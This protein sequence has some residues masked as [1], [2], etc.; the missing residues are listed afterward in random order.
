MNIRTSIA[1]LA[2]AFVAASSFAATPTPTDAV[3]FQKVAATA[4]APGALAKAK[5]M[6]CPKA[7]HRR[8]SS[9]KFFSVFAA[10]QTRV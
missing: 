7:E 6:H 10:S 9:D 8:G 2:L 1:A 3:G 5:K 4:A